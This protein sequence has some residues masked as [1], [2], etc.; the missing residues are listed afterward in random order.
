MTTYAH[1]WTWI[2]LN[3][4]LA[5][6]HNCAAIDLDGTA[7]RD[8]INM[9][10]CIPICSGELRIGIAEGH[11]QPRHFFVLK[12]VA[13]QFLEAGECTDG[14]FTGP[15]T[16]RYGEQVIVQFLSQGFALAGDICYVAVFDGD[17]HRMFQDAVFL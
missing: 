8:D 12:K 9:N 10:L 16:V 17:S 15:V 4:E 14:K 13:N 3:C 1:L 6:T 5:I 2:A 7:G 11:V